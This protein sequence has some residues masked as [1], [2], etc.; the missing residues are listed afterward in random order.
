MT[1]LPDFTSYGYQV[2]E[3]LNHNVQGG[4][5]TYKAVEIATQTPVVIKQFRFAT[6]SNWNEYKEIEREIEVLKGLNHQGIPKYLEQFNSRDG[7]CLVYEREVILESNANLEKSSIKVKEKKVIISLPPYQLIIVFGLVFA[8][9]S[10][11]LSQS[12]LMALG[13]TGMMSTVMIWEIGGL[14]A[15]G[16]GGAITWGIRE[17]IRRGITGGIK[18]AIIGILTGGIAGVIGLIIGWIIGGIIGLVLGLGIGL[19][20]GWERESSIRLMIGLGISLMLTLMIGRPIA[21]R[22]VEKLSPKVERILDNQFY[23]KGY[24]STTII[25]YLL[26]TTATSI[27]TGIGAVVGFSPSLLAGLTVSALPLAGMLIYPPIKRM[28]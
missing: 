27:L 4:R 8:L 16:I 1:N 21:L 5:I 9:I 6:Q 15:W 28:Q 3:I 19:M 22:M 24:Q 7:L 11:I 14:I 18:G 17:G 12:L 2:T 23:S 26:L 20:I 25:G 13:I 10:G